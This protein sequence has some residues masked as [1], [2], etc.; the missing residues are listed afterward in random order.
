MR[1]RELDGLRALAA[2]MVVLFH[3]AVA[4]GSPHPVTAAMRLGVPGALAN[5]ASAVVLFFVLSGLVLTESLQRAPGPGGAVAFLARRLLRLYPAWLAALLATWGASFLYPA[6]PLA[7]GLSPSMRGSLAVHLDWQQLLSSLA[8]PG[9]AHGQMPQGWTLALELQLSFLLPALVVLARRLRPPVLLGLAATGLVLSDVPLIQYAFPFT[10]G[11]VLGIERR[12]RPELPGAV[13]AAAGG[14][15]AAVFLLPPGWLWPIS[16]SLGIATASAGA[17]V[18]V[19]LAGRPGRLRSLLASAP[20]VRVGEASYGLYLL[21]FAVVCL[22]APLL[23]G[24]GPAAS[25]PVAVVRWLRLAAVVLPVSVLLAMASWRWIE[26]PAIAL[27][28]R[29]PR[30][31]GRF[32]NGT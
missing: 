17:A 21:H 31:E 27:G 32:P 11:V 30:R 25:L 15:A 2:T 22:V 1:R 6:L 3:C 18:L 26:R 20:L 16:P 10:L 8:S 14:L 4:V 23:V 7:G 29:I 13:A 9:T 24:D 19:R 12:E 5:G 28:R